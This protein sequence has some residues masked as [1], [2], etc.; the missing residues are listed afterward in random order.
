MIKHLI[1][2]EITFI[3]LRHLRY[4]L[5]VMVCQLMHSLT[6]RSPRNFGQYNACYWGLCCILPVWSIFQYKNENCMNLVVSLDTKVSDDI[7]ISKFGINL[8]RRLSFKWLNHWLKSRVIRLWLT[9][10]QSSVHFL[11]VHGLLHQ[12]LISRYLL[13]I[14]T[15]ISGRSLLYPYW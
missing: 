6:N 4:T 11:V 8:W 14:H 10:R 9:V 5:Q 1:V 2:V 3:Q 13:H 15:D 7:F 12:H